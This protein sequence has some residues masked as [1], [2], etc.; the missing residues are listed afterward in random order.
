MHFNC[1]QQAV[2]VEIEDED[3]IPS[4]TVKLQLKAKV[5]VNDIRM[6]IHAPSPLAATEQLIVFPCLGMGNLL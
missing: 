5:P 2:D 6:T 3:P 4:I 1:L